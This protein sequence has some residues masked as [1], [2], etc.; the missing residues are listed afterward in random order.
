MS[1]ESRNLVN[2]NGHKSDP[3]EPIMLQSGS[4]IIHLP[5]TYNNPTFEYRVIYGHSTIIPTR[6][7]I[8]HPSYSCQRLMPFASLYSMSSISNQMLHDSRVPDKPFIVYEPADSI[9]IKSTTDANHQHND[10]NEKLA[11]SPPKTKQEKQSNFN[12]TKHNLLIHSYYCSQIKKDIILT[13][14]ANF[15]EKES[16]VEKNEKE[17][18]YVMESHVDQKNETLAETNYNYESGQDEKIE[19]ESRNEKKSQRTKPV[20]MNKNE[21]TGTEKPKSGE[22]NE[23]ESKKDETDDHETENEEK[24]S[25]KKSESNKMSNNKKSKAKCD[26][27]DDGYD[28]L[29]PYLC[30]QWI[31]YGWCDC[32][33]TSDLVHEPMFHKSYRE[34]PLLSIDDWII[35]SGHVNTCRYKYHHESEIPCVVDG[36]PGWVCG[37]NHQCDEE[38]R[39]EWKRINDTIDFVDH[40]MEECA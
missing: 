17:T 5:N 34:C 16:K 22:I 28:D 9:P 14:N 20:I 24:V 30:C 4:D 19:M 32:D 40:W 27:E 33:G 21:M 39:I 18:K 29:P 10:K 31:L 15:C 7:P 11:S 38:E 3:P 8:Y 12:E 23:N 6:T 1:L 2:N 37:Y 26:D 13:N 36:C 25:T 35:T